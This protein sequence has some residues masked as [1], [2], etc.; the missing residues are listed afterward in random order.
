MNNV[1]IESAHFEAGVGWSVVCTSVVNGASRR[2]PEFVDLPETA[3]NADLEAAI[4]TK[5]V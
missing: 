2:G 5:Y 4:I 1:S 3:T